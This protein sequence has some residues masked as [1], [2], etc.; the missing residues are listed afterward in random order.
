MT[1]G[2]DAG[3]LDDLARRLA[4]VEERLDRADSQRAIAHLMYRYIYACDELKDADRIAELF[5][6]DAV[7][8]GQGNFAEF[9]STVGRDA[10]REMFVENPTMLPFTAHFLTNPVIGLSMDGEKG[11]GQWHTLEAATLREGR[12][13]VWMAAWYD[14]DF[15]RVD[16]D[17]RIRRIRYRDRFVAPYEEGWLRTRYVSPLT[18]VKQ[19]EV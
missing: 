18:L 10:I 16:G 19:T 15:V 1:D 14:N 7:W 13:Q 3:T 17:W 6:E 12:A 11:W 4:A 5:T 8:E 2:K 9:G